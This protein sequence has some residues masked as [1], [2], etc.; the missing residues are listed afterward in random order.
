MENK[1]KQIMNNILTEISK[2]V[3]EERQE[4]YKGK[5]I[6][7]VV[8]GHLKK[9]DN[10][11][12]EIANARAS[13]RPED[14]SIFVYNSDW[15]RIEATLN[16][17]VI[18]N[19]YIQSV[20]EINL[21]FGSMI[22]TNIAT[23][24]Y[25]KTLYN[26]NAEIQE[27]L[28][29]SEFKGD[30]PVELLERLPEYCVCIKLAQPI[31]L[32]MLDY[33][34]GIDHIFVSLNK[35]G[36]NKKSLIVT[37]Y[38]SN[39]CTWG[40]VWLELNKEIKMYHNEDLLEHIVGKFD[41]KDIERTSKNYERTIRQV[42]PYILYIISDKPDIQGINKEEHK[43]VNVQEVHKKGEVRLFP[44]NKVTEWNVGNNIAEKIKQY[45]SS[46]SN[47]GTVR[48]HIRRGHWHTYWTGSRSGKQ[49]P[50]IHWLFPMLVNEDKLHNN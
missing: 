31:E 22:L 25:T 27:Q 12:K 30:L 17:G 4:K 41:K 13:N 40:N 43:A 50:V 36:D 32:P 37:T 7:E 29:K 16:N 35:M 26:F 45:C 18:Y 1:E 9:Y 44:A 6:D 19:A 42:L 38:S 5:S 14:K 49:E 2:S 10:L 24:R 20:P 21:T 46:A 3:E 23:W 34:K 33:Q 8:N 39:N 48:P 47:G 15:A 28:L 11:N